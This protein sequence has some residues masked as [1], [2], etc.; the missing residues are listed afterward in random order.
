MTLVIKKIDPEKVRLFKAEAVKRGLLLHQAI[1]EAITLWLNTSR[2]AAETDFE[3]NNRL[4]EA[5]KEELRKKHRGEFAVI[6]EGRLVGIYHEKKEA[7]E[8]LRSLGVNHAILTQI[9]VDEERRSELEWWGGS[10][11]LQNAQDT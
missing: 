3:A 9:G 4:Y 11:E 5:M 7:L 2:S 10:I 8:A 1:E 6:A